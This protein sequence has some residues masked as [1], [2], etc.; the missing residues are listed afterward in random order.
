LP[1]ASAMLDVKS[2]SR[3][4][5]VPRMTQ[6]QRNAITSPATGLMIFQTNETPFYYYN[7]GTPAAPV[8]KKAGDLMLPYSGSAATTGGAVLDVTNESSI[9]LTYGIKGTAMA[10]NGYGIWG[11]STAPA[12]PNI[13]VYGTAISPLGA[14][15]KGYTISP[16]G[17]TYGVHGESRSKEG[18]GVYGLASADS[19]TT[20][21][22]YGFSES[23]ENGYGVYGKS[24]GGTGVY[25]AA[26]ETTGTNFGV[27]GVSHAT[28]GIGVTGM[29]VAGTG[30]NYGVQGYSLST[31]GVG[32]W[33]MAPKHGLY[34]YSSGTGSYAVKGVSAG[35]NGIGVYG[36]ATLANSTGLWGEGTVQGVYGLSELNT[37]K[38]VHGKVTAAT[39]SNYGVYGEAASTGGYGVYG[40][41]PKYGV[42]GLSSGSQGR[43]V[44]A[45]ATGVSSI[46]VY[47]RALAENSTAVW[48]EGDLY[49]FYA[50]GPGT[51]YGAAS[52]I[53]WKTNIVPI[54]K[55]LD[56]IIALRGVY[57][58]WNAANGGKHDVGM[59]AEE[60]GKVLPEIVVYEANGTDASGM[61]Y[62]KLTPLLIEGLKALKAENDLLKA[63]LEKLE[64]L[65][66]TRTRQ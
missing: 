7:A 55:P 6:A 66:D 9:L 41:S 28:T 29:A 57:F 40:K 20:Y 49:D 15:I 53:R 21:G 5:L 61:D 17:K 13:G 46:G 3:G 11:L 62:S 18:Y 56:K 38:G 39:G 33:G 63:R 59:I 1:N 58:D 51:N 30:T 32:V 36:E 2:S 26:T 19:G 16:T 45:E 8:W 12:G 48:G 50:T 60:V 44:G 31:D 35:Q 14:G 25:G 47:A 52:S 10:E 22:V 42:Y 54:E 64:K 37:G 4:L 27:Y 43:S 34:G 23:L 65:L 24:P